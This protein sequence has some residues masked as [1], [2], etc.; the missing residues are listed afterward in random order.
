MANYDVITIKYDSFYTTNNGTVLQEHEIL[1]YVDIN[2]GYIQIQIDRD[3]GQIVKKLVEQIDVVEQPVEYI[4]EYLD[5][6]VGLAKNKK[7]KEAEL[8][9]K[10]LAVRISPYD[11]QALSSCYIDF[12]SMLGNSPVPEF[13]SVIET[14]KQHNKDVVYQSVLR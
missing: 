13:D 12:N 14:I 10:K 5:Y 1:K 3:T 7:F 8:V 6:F 9:L 2:N 4:N 11:S